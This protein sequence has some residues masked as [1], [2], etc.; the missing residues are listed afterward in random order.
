MGVGIEEER[1]FGLMRRFSNI[2]NGAQSILPLTF[3]KPSAILGG[4]GFKVE[5][6]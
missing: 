4:E 1:K 3:L 2:P 6:G 5:T